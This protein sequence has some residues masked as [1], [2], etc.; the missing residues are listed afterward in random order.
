MTR[1]G[2]RTGSGHPGADGTAPPEDPRAP[3]TAASRGDAGEEHAGAREGGTRAG[4]GYVPTRDGGTRAG[5][6]RLPTPGDPAASMSLLN[7]LLRNPLD[8]GY[9]AYESTDPHGQ[10]SGPWAKVLLL[11]LAVVLGIGSTVAVRTL[12][13]PA[14]ENTGAIL[15]KQAQAQQATVTRLEGEVAETSRKVK[16]LSGTPGQSGV[17]DD[18]GTD[19]LTSVTAVTGPGLTVTLQD[20]RDTALD[21]RSNTGMIRDQDIRLVLNS[22]WGSGAEAISV[23]GHRIGPGTFVRTA[24]STILVNVTAVQSP[25]RI[26][27]IGDAD[28]LS[29]GLVR[30]STGDYLSALQ[31]VSG[32]RMSTSSAK[33]LHL[34]ALDP[35]K[36][37]YSFPVDQNSS[38]G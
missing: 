13:T 3:D 11:V 36:T 20:A 17:T 31:S 16:E 35:A 32:I 5:D 33:S 25:Y 37:T 4:E 28:A 7:Q 38:G 19:L 29:V 21:G 10:G 22:L 15:L 9:H 8:A 14:P 6:G 26:E 12:R 23:N 34:E 24:G 18:P 30:G 27:A 2:E 1:P